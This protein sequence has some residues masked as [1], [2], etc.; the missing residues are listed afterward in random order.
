MFSLP[1]PADELARKLSRTLAPRPSG[2]ELIVTD[3]GLVPASGNDAVLRLQVT[4]TTFEDSR[5]Q[6]WRV[7]IPLDP[8]DLNPDVMTPQAFVVT[9]R[10]N[11]E[12]WWDVRG[13]EPAVA[14]WGRRLD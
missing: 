13:A 2:L 4:V 1:L 12:E 5:G 7:E 11:L 6:H 10:A 8:A 9:V 3:V 14:A